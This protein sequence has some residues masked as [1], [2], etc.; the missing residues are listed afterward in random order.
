[1]HL[2][3]KEYKRIEGEK[4]KKSRE[5]VDEERAVALISSMKSVRDTLDVE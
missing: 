2:W 5:M 4:V 3:I 1:M